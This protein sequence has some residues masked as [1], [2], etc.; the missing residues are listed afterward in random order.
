M[1]VLSDLGSELSYKLSNHGYC[2]NHL[3]HYIHNVFLTH[4]KMIPFSVH[5]HLHKRHSIF[6]G[7]WKMSAVV[8]FFFV[9]SQI[10]NATF[11]QLL[12]RNKK[13]VIVSLGLNFKHF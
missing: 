3:S 7:I 4:H 8:F 11:R 1:S 5:F 9:L 2:I 13:T 12:K 10:G 6:K